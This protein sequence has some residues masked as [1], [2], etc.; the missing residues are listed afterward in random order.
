MI[1]WFV[2]HFSC[3]RPAFLFSLF[4]LFVGAFF[5]GAP[6]AGNDPPAATPAKTALWRTDLRAAENEARQ[7]NKPLLAVFRCARPRLG[8]KPLAAQL[9]RPENDAEL[10]GL[11]ARVVPVC[12]TD[13]RNVDL[14]RYVFDYDQTFAVLV[15]NPQT[16]QTLARFGTRDETGDASHMSMAGLKRALRGALGDFA[17]RRLATGTSERA[18]RPR[19][20]TAELFPLWGRTRTARTAACYHCHYAADARILARRAAGTFRKRELFAY[21]LPET[22]GVTL[23]RN[24]N[25]RVRSVRPGS[26]AH[27]AGLRAG[28]ALVRAN[29]VAIYSS[30]DFQ[31]TLDAV[32]DPGTVALETV[33][34]GKPR[35]A[36]LALPAGWRQAAGVDIS[37]RASQGGVPPFLAVWEEALSTSERRKLGLA[38][39]GTLALRVSV[40]FSGD[41]WAPL[42]GD[43]RVGDVIVGLDD[44]TLPDLSPRQFH[45]A[46]RL[47]HNVGDTAIVNVL[48]GTG[49][50]LRVPVACR[51][52]PPE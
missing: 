12:V 37:W 22:I 11:L 15:Q 5:L 45:A 44:Q 48:R 49:Q 41:K 32:R 25:N 47:R 42:R 50:R 1:R 2:T 16:G 43:L 3:L 36:T 23:D 51:D 24:E 39:A 27:V 31:F 9:A 34:A 6:V 35:R 30:A 8:W 38:P 20:F 4:A 46:F 10:A 26:P 28:D 7:T 17:A 33:R 52:A 18:P 40:V 19:P 14:A 13:F 21:P 29:D